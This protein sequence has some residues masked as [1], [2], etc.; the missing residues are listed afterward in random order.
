MYKRQ[1][2]RRSSRISDP[3]TLRSKIESLLHDYRQPVLVEE[4]CPGPEFTVGILGNGDAAKVIGVMEISPRTGRP[5][6][7]VY[8]IE[9][10]RN[11]LTE[12]EYR[13]PPSRPQHMIEQAEAA[14]LGAYRA[15][16]CRDIARVDLRVGTDGEP[17]FL[18]INPLPGLNPVTGDIVILAARRGLPYEALIGNIVSAART[19][20]GI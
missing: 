15:L 16:G 8:S 2:I 3:E 11:Y 13:V 5:E 19:R 7:F 1:G 14:A 17:K 18:E 12:V 4:F 10:K 9:A 6:E 20:Y